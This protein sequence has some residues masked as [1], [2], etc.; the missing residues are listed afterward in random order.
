MS[1]S[2]GREGRWRDRP[3]GSGPR[4]RRTARRMDRRAGRLEASVWG[5]AAGRGRSPRPGVGR[6]P[7]RSRARAGGG[8][9]PGGGDSRCAPGARNRCAGRW[10]AR[11][12][13]YAWRAGSGRRPGDRASRLRSRGRDPARQPPGFARAPVVGRAAPGASTPNAPGRRLATRPPR[14]RHRCASRRGW[15]PDCAMMLTLPL[16]NDAP[17][18]RACQARIG[19]PLP[20][21]QALGSPR[22]LGPEDLLRARQ[23]LRPIGVAAEPQG[24]GGH[25]PVAGR[26]Q[27]GPRRRSRMPR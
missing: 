23:D 16:R 19:V 2:C 6:V 27:R 9:T 20:V 4:A 24:D 11:S 13:R 12:R 21:P 25:A 7:R 10:C 17:I 3:R 1:G 18:A 15:W 5:S 26:A 8:S 14:A 22:G